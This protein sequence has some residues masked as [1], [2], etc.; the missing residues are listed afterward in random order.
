MGQE[1][2]WGEGAP[3]RPDQLVGVWLQE[4]APKCVLHAGTDMS[5]RDA[6]EPGVH[7]KCLPACHV[8]Q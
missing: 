6:P 3:V 1:S 2:S 4:Q 8:V 7:D 5:L